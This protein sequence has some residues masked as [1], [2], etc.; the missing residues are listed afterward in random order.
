MLWKYLMHSEKLRLVKSVVYLQ[1]QIATSPEFFLHKLYISWSVIMFQRNI[2]TA[3]P[4]EIVAISGNN[5]LVIVL[6]ASL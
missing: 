1:V 4:R 2:K 3:S 5:K 6:I